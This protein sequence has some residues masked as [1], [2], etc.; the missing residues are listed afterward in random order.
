MVGYALRWII[1]H[2]GGVYVKLN[3]LHPASIAYSLTKAITAVF[4]VDLVDT[5]LPDGSTLYMNAG[6]ILQ[7]NP[8]GRGNPNR[9]VGYY[10]QGPINP[11]DPINPQGP[12]NPPCGGG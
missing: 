1:L 7:G 12:I 5:L 9:L 4:S 6:K 3:I 2:F 11:Q 8:A 10:P